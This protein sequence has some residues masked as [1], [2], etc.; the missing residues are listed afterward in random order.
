MRPDPALS[1]ASKSLQVH[2]PGPSPT[3]VPLEVL[4]PPSPA[5]PLASPAQCLWTPSSAC[6]D[7]GPFPTP[8]LH[9][10]PVKANSHSKPCPTRD[11]PQPSNCSHFIPGPSC[12]QIQPYSSLMPLPKPRPQLP[13]P[14]P[15]LLQAPPTPTP[16]KGN[17]A[18]PSDRPSLACSLRILH[19]LCKS[20]GL[21]LT[22][23]IQ[24]DE[25]AWTQVGDMKLRNY[26]VE[27]MPEKL[28]YDLRPQEK[29]HA[30]EDIF[31]MAL[32]KVGAPA[33]LQPCPPRC[34]AP[35]RHPSGQPFLLSLTLPGLPWPPLP[36]LVSLQTLPI[37]KA[38]SP[39]GL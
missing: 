21:N 15:S 19:V 12:P 5:G 3:T 4:K 1:P 14:P 11:C 8:S 27:K 16:G 34:P 17:P 35:P 7:P 32:N 25:N 29:G 13:Y 36:S 20:L 31:Q 30:P 23:F 28:G 9:P 39:C 33:V 38:P 26:V 24:Y 6:P 22:K 2:S 37:P 10:T 18:S